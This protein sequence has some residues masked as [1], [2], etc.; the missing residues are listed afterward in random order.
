MPDRVPARRH[1][2]QVF[3]GALCVVAGAPAITGRT[4]SG[5]LAATLPA[6]LI[7]VWSVV[8]VAGGVLVVLAAVVRSSLRGLYLE[9]VA[10]LP[11]AI[12]TLA[13]GYA[14]ISVNG[15]KA[16][17]SAAIVFGFGVAEFARFRQVTGAL[18]RLGAA[19][20]KVGGDDA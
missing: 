16:I 6:W 9:C 7:V 11:L 14:L 19:L 15:A 8:L 5:S 1:P 20:G 4:H 13:Y 10:H 18:H 2:H 17:P 3:I 12:M